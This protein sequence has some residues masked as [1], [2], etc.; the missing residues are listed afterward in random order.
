[1]DPTAIT[2]ATT[3]VP[4]LA[5][6]VALLFFMHRP[7]VAKAIVLAGGLVSAAG[8]LVLLAGGPREPVRF[9]WFSSGDVALHFGFLYDGLSLAFG[10]VVALITLCIQTYSIGY[11]AKDPAQTRFFAMLGLFGWAMLSFVYAVDLLQ[12]FIFWELVGLASFFLIGFW[13]EKPA[14]AAAARKAFIMTRVGDVGLFIGILIILNT[15]GMFDI[16]GLLD[17]ETGLRAQVSPGM[18]TLVMLLVFVGIMGKSAQFPLHTWLPDA[19]QGPTPVSALLHSATMVAAGVYLFA[20]LNPLFMASEGALLTVLCISTVTALLSSTVAMVE[21]D[22]KKVLAYSSISQ[23]GFMLMALAAGGFFAGVFHLITHALFKALLFLCA[24]SYIHH[25]DS[26]EIEEIGRRGGRR[27]RWTTAGLLIGGGALAGIPPLAG[28]WSKEE[29]FAALSHHGATIFVAAAFLAALLTAYYTFRMIF[30]ILFPASEEHHGDAHGHG[31]DSPAVMLGPMML[32]AA[33]AVLAGFGGGWLARL[34]GVE[35]EHH[36]LLAMLPAIGVVALGI[37]WAWWDFG[38]R[39]APRTGLVARFR[40]LHTLFVNKWYIDAFYAAVVARLTD[41]LAAFFHTVENKGLDDGFD[42]AARGFV[43][44][45]WLTA[46]L[47]TGWVQS[48]AG[49]AVVMFALFGIYLGLR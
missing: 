12:A 11:M 6:A 40:P 2:L 22:I 49:T 46:R 31:H 45:G 30:L 1:M 20:R 34:L 36:S 33:G 23:L 28:F 14:A 27:M 47:Q 16:P 32:L 19:M 15:A 39:A 8:S 24:G 10:A 25:C 18:L 37:A 4:F 42:G 35:R 29:I 48:Y 43:Q 9:L 13:Y 41:R 21:R 38:R 44:S 7:A 17:P 3:F 26:M 5:F